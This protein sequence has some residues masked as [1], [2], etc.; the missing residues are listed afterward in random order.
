[1]LRFLEGSPARQ[2]RF[3]LPRPHHGWRDAAQRNPR[4]RSGDAGHHHLR[5]RLCR[6]GP[7]LAEVL[8]PAHGR[9]LERDEEFVRAPHGLPVSGVERDDWYSP[10]VGGTREHGAG[11]GGRQYGEGVAG[12]R[13]VHHVAANRAAILDLHAAHLARRGRKH[14][15]PPSH[16]RRPDQIGIRR[17]RADREHAAANLDRPQP[18]EP[19][20]VEK[21]R[22][23]QRPEVERHVQVGAAGQRRQRALVAQHRESL[24]DRFRPQQGA[25]RHRRGHRVIPLP[26]IAREESTGRSPRSRCTG[27][28]SRP[29]RRGPGRLSASVRVPLPP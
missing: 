8:P 1:M 4:R 25:A 9:D 14:R 6:P 13:R 12:G 22:R 5:N 11:V 20:Q 16:E 26:L 15:Q 17:Q 24:A 23:L 3:G 28:G 27:T 29:A 19:P 21:P 2:R 18:I 7:D 10:N